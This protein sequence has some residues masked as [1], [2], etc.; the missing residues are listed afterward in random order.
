MNCT[1]CG[2]EN[3]VGIKFCG[4]CGN[5]LAAGCPQC[6]AHSPAGFKFCGECGTALVA[7]S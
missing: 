2:F 4:E 7:P 6:G 5:R 3:P 1:T